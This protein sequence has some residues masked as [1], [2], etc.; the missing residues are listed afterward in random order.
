ME[1]IIKCIKSDPRQFSKDPKQLRFDYEE[2]NPYWNDKKF[3]MEVLKINYNFLFYASDDL[4]NDRNFIMDLID[5]S[6][7]IL[8]YISENLKDDEK[9]IL[10]SSS[11]YGRSFLNYASD[12]I[13]NNKEIV[14]KVIKIDPYAIR[15]ASDFLKTRTILC[16][17]AIV[18][19]LLPGVSF[20]CQTMFATKFT[21]PNTSSHST[22]K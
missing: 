10:Y 2:S 14:M 6:G 5:I 9:L 1:E 11:R 13:K 17:C 15:H 19:A 3:V 18:E 20:D 7:D 22:F 4:K 16:V 8:G 12:R 21:R